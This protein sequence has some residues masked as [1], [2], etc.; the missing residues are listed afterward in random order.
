MRA[1][2]PSPQAMS[3]T[4]SQPRWR[5]VMIDLDGTLVDS[6][7]DLAGAVNL[8]L[9]QLGMRQWPESTIRKWV[10]NGVPRL[11]QRALTGHSDGMP[12]DILFERAHPMFL[13]HY[14]EH[15]CDRSICYPGVREGLDELL[16]M[17]ARLACVTNKPEA[18]TNP[19]LERLGV[20]DC[21]EIILGGDSLPEK[22]P[23]PAPLQHVART[24]GVDMSECVLIGDSASDIE[25]AKAAGCTSIC[26]SYGYNQG[27]DLGALGPNYIVPDF[28]A[29]LDCIRIRH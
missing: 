16:G 21:F 28:S 22:K 26:V 10:G 15:L 4:G 9:E 8:M 5:I 13:R 19:L 29:A 11:V 1:A 25:S 7:P 6:V 23:H 20:L 24:M 3:E 27:V 17:N 2:D 12:E 14:S 18:F